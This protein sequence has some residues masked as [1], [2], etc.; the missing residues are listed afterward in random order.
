MIFIQLIVRS[1][2]MHDFFMKNYQIYLLIFLNNVQFKQ[3][4]LLKKL[5]VLFQSMALVSG[6]V[7]GDFMSKSFCWFRGCFFK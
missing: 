1:L 6:C 7:V 4:R 5:E 3:G 2:K